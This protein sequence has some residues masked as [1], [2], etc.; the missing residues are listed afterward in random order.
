MKK[1]IILLIVSILFIS[2]SAQA[3][4]LKFMGIPLTGTITQFQQK[5]AAKGV[6][7]DKRDSET[8]SIGTRVFNGNFA[9][10]KAK[11]VVWYDADTKIVYGAKA[12]Y[13][14][15]TASSRDN[16][17]DELKSMLSSKYAEERSETE[18]K[19]GLEKF[20]IDVTDDSGYLFVGVI[21]LYRTQAE[22][23]YDDTFFVHVEYMDLEN[24]NKNRDSKMNDL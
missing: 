15:N 3:E 19:D 16:K 8:A 9:G 1:S 10:S 17:Y 24:Y 7:Y 14:C 6:T 23:P 11:I 22:F 21:T 5:L 20:S 2:I 4:H 12:I 13:E 18:Y